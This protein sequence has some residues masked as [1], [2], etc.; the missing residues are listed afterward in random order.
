AEDG[1]RLLGYA[2]LRP[3]GTRGHIADILARPGRPDVAR[4]LID[5]GLRRLRLDGLAAVECTLPVR[6]P[7]VRA[8]TAA[9]FVRLAER[10]RVMAIKFG[11][12]SRP[13]SGTD[14]G[15]LAEPDARMHV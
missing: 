8:L 6:H 11:V 7:Y 1:A 13:G 5:Q 15:F 10:S 12:S 14:L 3:I 4:S 2:V 9:G